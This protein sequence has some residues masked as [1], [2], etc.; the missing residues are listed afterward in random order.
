MSTVQSSTSSTNPLAALTG[1]SSVAASSTSASDIQDRFLKL[2]VTQLK[3]Q[4]P[5]NPMDNAQ[6]TSQ[7]SQISTVSGIEKLNTTM[8]SLSASFM[9]AQSLQSAGLIGHTVYTDGNSLAFNGSTPISGGVNLSQS[10]DSV[11]VNII[12]PSGNVVRQM[13]LGAHQAGL[14]AFQWDG[15]S[16]GGANVAA[17]NYTFQV[18]ASSGGTA[19]PAA[20]LMSGQVS[21]VL[22]GSDGAHAIVGGVG[23]V[24]VSQIKQIM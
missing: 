21:S 13:D 9:S 15:L 24:P 2:L 10:A 19:V 4:D 5:L 7:L 22:L 8:Q 11:K 16:D 12:G 18:T 20:T 6:L 1:S 23:D 14:T 17:G 3:N